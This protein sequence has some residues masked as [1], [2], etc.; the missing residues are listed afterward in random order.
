MKYIKQL[1]IILSITFIA[2]VLKFILPFPIPTSIYGM[3]ILFTL[4]CLKIVK[5][6]H[7]ENVAF[8][9][10][11]CMGIM[12]VPAGVGIVKSYNLLL[13]LLPA[14]VL[15]V[16]LVTIIVMIVSGKVTDLLVKKEMK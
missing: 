10:I 13:P 9:L 14:L 1:S 8:F 3:L 2:E 6:E 7:I 15:S 11:T 4:L 16:V 5:P 12:F